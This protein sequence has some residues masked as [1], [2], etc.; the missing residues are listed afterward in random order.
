MKEIGGLTSF[1]RGGRNS[2]A[3][4][5]LLGLVD[6]RVELADDVGDE[7]VVSDVDGLVLTVE[8]AEKVSVV[9]AVLVGE[10]VPVVV[11]ETVTV[12]VPEE[13]G[14]PVTDEVTVDVSVNVRVVLGLVDMRKH[15]LF[16]LCEI[17]TC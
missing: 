10:R 13:V 6:R 12:L 17:S 8:V 3:K 2:A 7:V 5:Y 14:V 1:E 4:E 9:V 15:S 11:A 16:K